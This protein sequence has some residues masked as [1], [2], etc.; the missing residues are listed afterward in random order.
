MVNPRSAI[1]AYQSAIQTTPPLQAVV[2]LYDGVLVRIRNAT[3]AAGNGDF[4]EQFNQIVRANDILRGLMAALD[5]EQGGT[6]AIH[7]RD[8]YEANMRALLSAVGRRDTEQYLS[9]VV[10]SL[11]ELRNAWAEIAGMP[12]S[13]AGG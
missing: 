10:V 5:V 11:R 9:R 2:M 1:S 6:L 8:A 12:Q 13:S 3:T 4:S 7:L